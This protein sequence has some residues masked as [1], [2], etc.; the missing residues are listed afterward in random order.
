MI[1]ALAIH[2][3]VGFEAV[4]ETARLFLLRDRSRL[5]P[6]ERLGLL[7]EVGRK[8]RDID[9]LPGQPFDIA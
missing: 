1:T 2:A 5:E 6:L 7:D 8:R 4:R 9:L 3:A